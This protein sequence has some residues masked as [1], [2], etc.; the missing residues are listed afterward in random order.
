ME[1]AT[2]EQ[3]LA[4]IRAG[5]PTWVDMDGRSDGNERL[6][7]DLEIHP[8]IIE[9]VFMD[10]VR[11]KV[12]D[13]KDYVYVLFHAPSSISRDADPQTLD[14]AEIDIILGQNY[15]VTHHAQPS[16]A[17][18][19]VWGEVARSGRAIKKGAAWLAHAVLDRVVD[20]Y[21]PQLDVMDDEIDALEHEVLA[22][23]GRDVL[24]RI[25]TIKRQLQ[26]LR[27]VSIHQKEVLYRLSR[28]EF[29]EIPEPLLPFFR[30][31]YDHF[32]RVTDLAESYRDLI[33]GTFEAHLS[34]QSNKMN[35]IMK[36]LTLANT[37]FLPLTFI[38]GIYGM[39]FD[40]M[41]EL[42][43]PW[44]YPIVLASMGAVAFAIVT[45]YRR[46]RWL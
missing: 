9:D 14:L 25:F 26:Q 31:V 35:A 21:L 39:N 30:D 10:C 3:A 20:D 19:S 7:T 15:V 28:G 29:D 38:A 8:L 17:L 33:A 34:V 37:V 2:L 4:A 36:T 41:P 46:K 22:D 44:A 1:H 24:Q 45:F 43:R 6:L 11:P 32:V 13:Y 40:H 27:R 5:K 18:D 42:R 23:T 16:K 12:E